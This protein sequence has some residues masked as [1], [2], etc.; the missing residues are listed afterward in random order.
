MT[1][2]ILILAFG[3]ALV[4]GIELLGKLRRDERRRL[5]RSRLLHLSR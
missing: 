4:V 2:L 1:G 5:I 3:V